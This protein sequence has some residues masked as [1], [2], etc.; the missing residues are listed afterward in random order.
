MFYVKSRAG[1][2]RPGVERDQ[3]TITPVAAAPSSSPLKRSPCHRGDTTLGLRRRRNEKSICRLSD[4]RETDVRGAGA[5]R[6]NE[7][8]A[9][10][11][12]D[13]LKLDDFAANELLYNKIYYSR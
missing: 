5:K 12:R 7:E 8:G 13:K 4:E 2:E 9:F 10:T 6:F 1:G 3:L 11:P